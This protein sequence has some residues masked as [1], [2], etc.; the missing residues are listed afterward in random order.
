MKKIIT[1]LGAVAVSATAAHAGG[2]ERSN[3]STAILFEKG[4]YVEFSIGHVSPSVSG[5][6]NL[7]P[8]AKT[9]N[10]A[11][12]YVQLGGGLKYSIND[13]LDAAIIVDQPFGADVSYPVGTGYPF[14]GSTAELN[15]F[16]VTGLLKYRTASNVSVFGGIRYQTFEAIASL[17]ALGNYTV[18]GSK[19]GGVGYV[20]GVA[21]EKPEI[22]LRVAL[23]YNSKIKHKIDTLERGTLN[24]TTSVNTPQSVNLEFQS[25][26]AADTLVFGSVR[27][28][29]WSKFSIDP[30]NYPPATPLVSYAKNTVT[31]N[32]GVG[33]KL[34]ENWAV[35]AAVGYEK[36]SGGFSSNLGPTDGKKSL[37]LGAVYT[38]GNMKITGGVSY[39]K[40]GDATTALNAAATARGVFTKNKA[41]G[42]GIKVGYSF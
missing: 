17:P 28:V 24:S 4:N 32:L 21:Y 42:V 13:S 3:Q 20:A 37:T 2:V 16:S 23:T 8:L 38:Q 6:L 22:A 27:W 35:S 25:G 1:T 39:V 41:V 29:E 31:F 12:N 33:R 19:D 5:S 30:A 9:G 11:K 36:P 10:M 15:A 34:N 40:V 18:V 26:V 14:A 7:N